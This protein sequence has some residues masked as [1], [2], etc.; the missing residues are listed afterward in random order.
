MLLR[1]PSLAKRRLRSELRAERPA[2][3]LLLAL[4]LPITP[5]LLA[6]LLPPV[7]ALLLAL[8]LPVAPRLL[9]VGGS[10]SFL[11]GLG[12]TS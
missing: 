7:A 10:R 5:R 2:A 11:H 9:A 12:A 3:A 6:A 8:P 1:R 4:P